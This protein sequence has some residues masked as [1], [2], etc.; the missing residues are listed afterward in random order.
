M[1]FLRAPNSEYVKKTEGG[2]HEGPDSDAFHRVGLPS[3][4]KSP[5][6]QLL[7]KMITLVEQFTFVLCID[8]RAHAEPIL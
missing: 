6:P 5:P 8:A 2:G 7:S 1:A 4:N 3:K